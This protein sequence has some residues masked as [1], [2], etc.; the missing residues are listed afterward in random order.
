MIKYKVFEYVCLMYTNHGSHTASNDLLYNFKDIG[1]KIIITTILRPKT[2]TIII[3]TTITI[4]LQ[5]W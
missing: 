4:I 3:T 2:I 5:V 1:F